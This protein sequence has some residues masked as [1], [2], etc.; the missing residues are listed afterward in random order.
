MNTK[1][2]AAFQSNLS[3]LIR[4]PAFVITVNKIFILG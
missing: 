1:R 2:S 3:F 4:N